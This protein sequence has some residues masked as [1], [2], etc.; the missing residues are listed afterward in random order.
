MGLTMNHA[1]KYLQEASLILD[2]INRDVIEKIIQCL[3][4]IRNGKGRLFFLGVGGSAS[5]CSHAVN[6][7]RKIASMEAYTPVDN[8]SELTARTNDEGWHTVF[9]E[10]L[11]GSHLSNRDGVF[12]LSVGGG[13]REKN[14]SANLVYALEYAKSKNAKILGIVGRDGGYTAQ[15]ADACVIVSTVN[16]DSVTPHT[17]SFQSLIWHLIISD[18]RMMKIQNKWERTEQNRQTV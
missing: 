14:I 10:W 18:P 4:E 2:K 7:F 6:D 3:I 9:E 8:V 5:N 15:V 1:E 11:K 16:P 12:V 17:E 13:N